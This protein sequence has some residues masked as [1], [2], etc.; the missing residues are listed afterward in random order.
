MTSLQHTSKADGSRIDWLD[1][2]AWKQVSRRTLHFLIGCNI[3]DS[4][5]L[6]YLQ[7]HY[8]GSPLWLRMVLAMSAGVT[9]SILLEATMLKLRESFA[10]KEA[11]GM[12]TVTS[13]ISILG[14]EFAENLT[15]FLL[16]GVV[17]P[18]TELWFWGA[19]AISLV[20]GFLAPL[21]YNYWRFKSRGEAC[22]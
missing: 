1:H 13:F 17:V 14:M 18:I 5:M 2:S 12:A 11:F 8:H 15:D 6:I 3:G 16:T 7:A 19:L 9:T 4:G 21:P 20:V 10:W 22:H